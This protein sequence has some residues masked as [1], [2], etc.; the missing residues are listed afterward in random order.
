[1][2]FGRFFC[3]RSNTQ[4]FARDLTLKTRC[5]QLNFGRNKDVAIS[6]HTMIALSMEAKAGSEYR[7]TTA[8]R[9][10]SF[11]QVSYIFLCSVKPLHEATNSRATWLTKLM[12]PDGRT[13]TNFGSCFRLPATTSTGQIARA[14]LRQAMQDFALAL[15]LQVLQIAS[16]I[17]SSTQAFA[18]GCCTHPTS[19]CTPALRTG[20]VR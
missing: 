6:P 15:S 16:K 20:A 11:R 9:Q 5:S 3:Q 8:V 19:D 7:K 17:F 13:V 2:H 1:M 18:A 10:N 12:R 4:F 14:Q